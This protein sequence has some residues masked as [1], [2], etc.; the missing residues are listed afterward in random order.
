MDIFSA[1]ADA[2]RRKIIELLANS[3]EL[4][5][6]EISQR[7]AVSAPAISQHLKA[8]REANL[9][10]VEKRGQQR[11]YQLNPRAILELETWA[12]EMTQRWNRRFDVLERVLEAEK[13]KIRQSEREQTMANL[14]V[15]EVTVTRVF[16]APRELVFK[17]FTDPELIAQWWGPNEFDVAACEVDP[18]PGGVFNIDMRAPD[19]AVFEG[20]GA[21]REVIAPER[22]VFVT[23][24]FADE[25]GR[26]Q[27]EVLYTLTFTE[28]SGKTTLILRS[29][30]IHATPAMAEILPGMEQGWSES[31]DKLAG[32]L[33]RLQAR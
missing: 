31:F 17:A 14:D 21:F 11:I 7:F 24:G 8:L 9:V 2:N 18:R 28:Q 3:G 16:D 27:L 20:K 33:G 22:L 10:L 6:S 15:S 25:A 32:S 1:L 26:P 23:Q 12:S 5:A 29:E 30:L 19:G 13:K 4:S